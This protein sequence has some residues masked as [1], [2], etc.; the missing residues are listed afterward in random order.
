MKRRRDPDDGGDHWRSAFAFLQ[1]LSKA[2]KVA[3]WGGTQAKKAMIRHAAAEAERAI[4]EDQV[5]GRLENARLGTEEDL[6]K[7]G[8][9]DG[10]GFLLGYI[11]GRPVRLSLDYHLAIMAMA[12]LGKTTSLTAPGIIR[13]LQG[14]AYGFGAESAAILDWKQSEM[15]RMAAEGV[16][17]VTGRPARIL[18]PCDPD[19]IEGLN[20]F[21]DII[22]GAAN[23]MPIVDDARARLHVFFA[24]AIATAGQNAW[25]DKRG[26]NMALDFTVTTAHLDPANCT[27]GGLYDFANAS[28]A[29][30]RGF[31]EVAAEHTGLEGG[32]IAA[33]ANAFLNRYDEDDLREFGW[34]MQ[35]MADAFSL[36]APGSYFRKATEVTT[37]DIASLR[38]DPQALF[39]S[40]PDKYLMSAGPAVSAMLDVIVE[41]CAYAEGPHRVSI[42]AEEFGA[43]S[44]NENVLKW[45]RTYRS[46]GIRFISVVQDRSGFSR[47]AKHGGHKPFEENSVKLLFGISD[48]AH[49]RDLEQRA[50]KRAVLIGTASTSLGLKVPGR[51]LG[52]TETLRPVL[53][54]SEIAQIGT[55]KALLD[56][57]GQP[58]FILDRPPWWDQPD[59]APFMRDAR[60]DRDPHKGGPSW[61]TPSP[62]LPSNKLH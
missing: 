61:Q 6:E 48:P 56:I 40:I 1:G 24:E 25:I 35:S 22:D 62:R 55:G 26:R 16:A 28:F 7:L 53:A 17:K 11:N 4:V 38:T 18:A 60:F 59:I 44:F 32:F 2:L 30:V 15:V 19:N 54:A 36:F 39:I 12:G 31:M 58:L 34:V 13:L 8:L 27:P 42:L 41:G 46:L 49:L 33:S 29:D 45:V 14:D 57:P 47:Y 5:S 50:G 23:G 3:S 21:Q 20:V 9:L 37:I 51:N 10:P 52:V 43:L